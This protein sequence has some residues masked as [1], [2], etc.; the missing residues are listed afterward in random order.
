M[1]ATVLA[2]FEQRYVTVPEAGCWLWIGRAKPKG[3]GRIGIGRNKQFAA[4]RVS[5]ELFRGEIPAGMCVCHKCDTPSCVN[6]DHLFLGTHADNAGDRQRKGRGAINR[7]GG[8][9]NRGIPYEVSHP[10]APIGR[11]RV[12]AP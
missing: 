10:N 12:G 3:Y 2:R 6:P 7:S 11:R 8:G 4:H 1:S 5:W 9:W